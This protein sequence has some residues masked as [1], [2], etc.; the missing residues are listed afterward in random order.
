[1]LNVF[2][3]KEYNSLVK[4]G[5]KSTSLTTFQYEEVIVVCPMSMSN[6]ILTYFFL[7][8]KL[9]D[10]LARSLPIQLPLSRNLKYKV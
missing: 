10:F 2:G 6:K 5:S 8:S 9:Y 3:K 1:M 7:C 4:L